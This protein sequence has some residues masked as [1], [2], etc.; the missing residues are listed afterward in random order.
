MW[1]MKSPKNFENIDNMRASFLLSCQTLLKWCFLR[2]K[3]NS[4]NFEHILVSFF[5]H[6][7]VFGLKINSWFGK[8]A[9][10][11]IMQLKVFAFS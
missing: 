7:T 3:K 9:I 1:L 11:F 4:P 2:H 6:E 5:A 10:Y 8:A